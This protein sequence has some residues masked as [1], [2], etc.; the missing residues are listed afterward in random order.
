MKD[1]VFEG[2][3]VSRALE[4]ASLGLGLPVAQLRYVV[5]EEG[6][7]PSDAGP[8]APARVAVLLDALGAGGSTPGPQASRAPRA[9]PG[10][11]PQDAPR[12]QAL[13]PGGV[14]AR[15]RRLVAAVAEAAQEPLEV[16]F[17]DGDETLVV[18]VRGAGE[19]LLLENGGEALR[20]LEHLLQRSVAAD[21]P[22]RVQ[23]SSERFRS[24]RDAFLQA[25]ALELAA[26]VRQD[27]APRETEPLNSYDR[28]IVH[29]AVQGLPGLRS[30]S[31]GEGSRRRVTV[32]LRP[33]APPEPTPEVQ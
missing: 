32:A 25:R 29:I 15:L 8:G 30:F 7:P 13:P 23:L 33:D 20:A 28:R 2:R 26:A 4:A 19:A 10:P 17:E 1:R 3:D 11:G 22:R 12:A 5:L 6:R 24:E 9:R 16:S 27:G 14:K 18:R 31:V 21:E